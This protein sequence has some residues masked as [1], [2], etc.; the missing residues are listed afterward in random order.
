LA[1]STNSGTVA[2]KASCVGKDVEPEPLTD[3]ADWAE[4]AESP[5]NQPNRTQQ[6]ASAQINTRIKTNNPTAGAALRR[7]L[8]AGAGRGVGLG[9][10]LT[11]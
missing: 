10:G 6:N 1:N 3:E 5:P 11:L 7:G 2:G 9:L 8:G 4:V